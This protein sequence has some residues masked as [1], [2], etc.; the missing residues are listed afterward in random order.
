MLQL[1]TPISITTNIGSS[2]IIPAFATLTLHFVP[3]PTTLLLA[4]GGF[5][6]LAALGRRR[7]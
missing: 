1:V 6:V 5:A 4:V 2:P 3:E 7:L